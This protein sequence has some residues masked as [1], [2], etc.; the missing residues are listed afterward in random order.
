[1][2]ISKLTRAS[3]LSLL[4]A[5]VSVSCSSSAPYQ[6]DLGEPLEVTSRRCVTVENRS[7]AELALCRASRDGWH[8]SQPLAKGERVHLQLLPG[9]YALQLANTARRVPLPVPAE[10]LGYRAATTAVVA[11]WPWPEPDPGWCWIPSGV[12]LRGDDLGIGQEDERPVA[13]L[14]VAGFWMAE[15]E[16]SNAQYVAFLN[17]IDRDAVEPRWLDFDGHKSHIRWD[18]QRSRFTTDRPQMPAVTVSWAGASA[19]CEWLTRE[20]GQR[21]RLPSEA[22]W[23]KAARGPGSRV[24]A[25]GDTFCSAKA[26]QESGRLRPIGSFA[27][28]GFGL[29]DMTGNAFEW[30]SDV[31]RRDAYA[32]A[33]ATAPPLGEGHFMALRGG[34]FVLD[35]IFVRNSMRMRLRPQVRA[36]DVG[37][38]VLRES[39]DA[40]RG[41]TSKLS[42]PDVRPPTLQG[43]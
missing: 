2:K 13:T 17:S 6:P 31:Y 40:L 22:E 1:M 15:H 26:N 14:E 12:T 24:Y 39:C 29:Y 4:T 7:G 19:Y 36:D 30:T 8:Q 18:S 32:D 42:Q 9:R 27:A 10:E 35:G 3:C 25:Y 11:V 41:S 5:L 43:Q 21:H 33:Q 23:E 20:A 37:F 34:S 16:T 28:N 38:R